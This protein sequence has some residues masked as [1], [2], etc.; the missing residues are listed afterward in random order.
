MIGEKI[1]LIRISKGYSQ[2]YMAFMLNIS[3]GTYSKLEKDNIV[4]TIQRLF[5]IAEILEVNI[6]ELLP[7]A[8]MGE[9]LALNPL[10]KFLTP[11]KISL[12]KLLFKV[13]PFKKNQH[14]S[15]LEDH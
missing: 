15:Q 10:I 9:F 3:Q 12:Y 1:R 8:N 4:I 5:S 7:D 11:L 14:I 2:E 6:T 13:N